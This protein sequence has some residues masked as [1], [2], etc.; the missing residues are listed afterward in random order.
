VSFTFTIHPPD[1]DL[2]A[3][4]AFDNQIGRRTTVRRGGYTREAIILRAKVADDGHSAEI[5]VDAELSEFIPEVTDF[6]P[7]SFSVRQSE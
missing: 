5:T 6:P 4:A 1:G 2:F 7:G 3:S